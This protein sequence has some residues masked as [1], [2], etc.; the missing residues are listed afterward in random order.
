MATW[1]QTPLAADPY[2]RLM[3]QA[4]DE[5]TFIGCPTAFQSWFGRPGFGST[6]FSPVASVVDIDIIRGSQRVAALV[7]R[8]MIS[9]PLGPSQLNTSATRYTAFS[10]RFP[11]ALEEGSIS[12]DQLEF[13]GAGENPYLAPD[14][15][16]RLR[17]LALEQHQ[18]QVRRMV[19]LFERLAAQAI[20]TGFQDAIL[21]TANPD[22]QFDF[23]RA[24]T[25]SWAT[26]GSGGSWANAASNIMLDIEL[27][28][29]LIRQDAHV[30]PDFMLLGATAMAGMLANTALL[31]TSNNFRFNFV[32]M[33]S[34]GLGSL[35]G[36][37]SVPAKFQRLIDGGLIFRG[38]LET[39]QGFVL[40]VFTY[41]DTYDTNAIPAVVTPYM[42]LV[43]ALIGSSDA[44]CDRYFGP[45]ERLPLTPNE[46]AEMR[47]LTGID[48]SA[49]MMPPKIAGAGDVV[50]SNMFYFDFYKSGRK[51]LIVE[52]Q[53]APIFSP[54]MTDAWVTLDCT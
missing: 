23:R 35:A 18:E 14:H 10:R 32:N 48:P 4:F 54:T 12:A 43:D 44:I 13:R 40:S 34:V 16:T 11:L 6:K 47:Y 50:N 27:G 1:Q 2:S 29:G 8:G 33:G 45:P 25:H 39:P 22:F 42:P 37:N 36:P 20:L 9:K 26:A 31:A 53:A 51:E 19:R 49:G 30:N 7:P 5:R 24:A 52:T 41:M 28:C 17:G 46:L 15:L 38:T 3:A 21:G